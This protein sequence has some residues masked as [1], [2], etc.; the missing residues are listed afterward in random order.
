MEALAIAVAL[1]LLAF[2]VGENLERTRAQDT[3]ASAGEARER[4]PR[5][6]QEGPR[7][8]T[9]FLSRIVP[10]P[11][12]RVEG[13]R[14]PSSIRDLARRLPLERKVAQ[15]F[16]W[17]FEGQDLTAPIYERMLRYDLGGI[18]IAGRNYTDPQQLATLAG[19]AKAI[20]RNQA[21]VP[22][23]VGAVQEGAEF[24]S[25]ADLP[26]SGAPADFDTPEAA[27]AAAGESAAT[28]RALGVDLV[29][30]PVIDVSLPDGGALGARA[31]SDDPQAVARFAAAAVAAY[32]EAGVLAAPKHFPGLGAASQDTELGPAKVGVTIEQLGRR[33]LVA[34]RAAIEHGGA[35]AVLVGHGA[36]EPDD[37]VTPASLSET[38]TTDL[39]RGRLGFRGLAIADDLS[40][41]AVTAIEPVPDAAV[42]AI[43]AGNDMVVLSGPL[44]DQEAAYLAVLNAVR[45]GKLSRRRVDEAVLRIL[46]AKRE[47]GLIAPA[48]RR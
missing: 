21:H 47:F 4:A 26:P 11:P 8:R 18:L 10:P 17:G 22:P 6:A 36:Y 16:L 23:F 44:A 40:A 38:M 5:G 48:G 30:G 25:F 33:D 39:L 34:F 37:F 3:S 15:L 35:A 13:P 42:E 28:L 12:E 1:A 43:R 46:L 19:E 9:S 20:A 32:G 29:L 2:A 7:A 14:V 41:P 24:N 45:Q 31:Y 27:A